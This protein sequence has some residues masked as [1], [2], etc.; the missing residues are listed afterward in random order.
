MQK[1]VH[2]CSSFNR[3]YR[4]LLCFTTK[5]TYRSPTVFTKPTLSFHQ[6]PCWGSSMSYIFSL[7]RFSCFS[8]Q[9]R[10]KEHTLEHKQTITQP[11]STYFMLPF[12]HPFAV[13]TVQLSI[14]TLCLSLS[15]I[16]GTIWCCCWYY[17]SLPLVRWRLMLW[18]IYFSFV[19]RSKCAQ[20]SV[21]F[22]VF[23]V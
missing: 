4:F 19:Y 14:A 7:P 16:V 8:E 12:A 11:I 18:K 6:Q 21:C 23:T 1:T 15:Y 10:K 22:V 17:F 3:K 5:K 9:R 2:T 20:F 13:Q